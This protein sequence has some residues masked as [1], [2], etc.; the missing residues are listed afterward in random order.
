MTATNSIKNLNNMTDFLQPSTNNQIDS[1]FLWDNA[2]QTWCKAAHDLT[3]QQ[4]SVIGFEMLYKADLALAD[5][6][7][8]YSHAFTFCFIIHNTVKYKLPLNSLPKK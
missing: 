1:L 6:P 2:D 5:I 3:A 8:Y 4:I 7:N